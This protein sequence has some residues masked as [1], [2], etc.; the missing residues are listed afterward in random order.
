M[1]SMIAIAEISVDEI[2]NRSVLEPA[3]LCSLLLLGSYPMTQ[4]YQHGEDGRR[5]DKTISRMLGITG[6]F[7]WTGIVFFFAILGFYFYFN[8]LYNS[9]VFFILII[10]LLPV[11]VYFM[12]WF[13]QVMKNNKKAD[14][15]STMMLNKLSSLGFIFFFLFLTLYN[16]GLFHS[17]NL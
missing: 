16:H 12:W 11:L 10:S 2:F 5:G 8:F 9:I 3:F 17:L 14:F 1:M 4:I 6:T 13:F 15:E 7:V